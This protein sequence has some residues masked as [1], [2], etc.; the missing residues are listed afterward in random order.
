MSLAVHAPQHRR[1]VLVIAFSDLGRDP[2]VNRQLRALVP[3]YQV[4][5]AGFADPGVPGVQF[6]HVEWPGAGKVASRVRNVP[7]RLVREARLNLG[8]LLPHDLRAS[9]YEGLY[10]SS[11]LV[12]DCLS[13]LSQLRPDVVIANDI[14]A[15]PLAL[16]VASGAPVIF[17]AH[18]YAPREYDNSRTFRMRIE[19]YRRYLGARYIPMAAAMTTVCRG[20]ADSYEA[21]T[22]VRSIIITNAPAY[23]PLRPFLP[24][25]EAPIRMVHHGMGAPVRKI[26]NMIRMM[27][28]LD[29]R[30][31]LDFMLVPSPARYVRRLEDMAAGDGRIRFRPLVPMRE[32]ARATNAY[33]IGLFLLEPTNFNYLHA[34]PNKF[35]EFI[36]ARLAIAIG[37]SPEMAALV[38]R[39]D[40]GV[41]APD[42]SPKALAARLRSVTR[43]QITAWKRNADVVA[44]ELSAENNALILQDLVRRVS[45]R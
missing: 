40:L 8:S 34:L 24:G 39:H 21:D 3:G 13:K 26:E 42:F 10:W 32:L 19:P 12:A 18:E 37:P 35:F 9:A 5:A 20:V 38:R 44:K 45:E 1:L 22:G 43:D 16:R 25:D 11:T 36:Q 2:R 7:R 6:I 30:F 28:H 27:E 31:V 23:E 33:D 17:D 4:V 29:Q 15:L 41:V 14:D